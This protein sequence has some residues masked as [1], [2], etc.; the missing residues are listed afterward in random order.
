M[1]NYQCPVCGFKVVKIQ[2]D[3][4]VFEKC[5]SCGRQCGYDYQKSSDAAV[6]QRLRVEW[7]WE[8]GC[9]WFGPGFEPT[10]WSPFGQMRL[11]QLS[12]PLVP[13]LMAFFHLN[14]IDDDHAK[15]WADQNM[16]SD[17]DDIDALITISMYGMPRGI[18]LHDY[19][20]PKRRKF[21]YSEEF[22]L[23][24]QQLNT[25]DIEQ[26]RDY[27]KWVARN[28]LSENIDLPEVG[29]GYSLDDYIDRCVDPLE[30]FFS[31]I[32][33]FKDQ[34]KTLNDELWNEIN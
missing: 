18:K 19:K 1:N 13:T 34:T 17:L 21:S 25:D 26:C 23:R 33:M 11:A 29:F 2:D 27:I 4:T 15:K 12:Y 8:E 30:Y 5:S 20:F 6:Y 24:T 16:E 32:D 7:V 28:S 3:N 22:V 10:G 14:L 31:K 9:R